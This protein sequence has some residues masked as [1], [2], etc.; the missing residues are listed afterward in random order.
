MGLMSFKE[1]L[2]VDYVPAFGGNRKLKE[3]TVIGIK[4]MNNDGSI[5]FMDTLTD[6][7]ADCK[8]DE[9]RAK[10]SKEVA[11]QTFID[12]V[13]YVK[14]YQV[15]VEKDKVIDIT[16]GEDLYKHGSKGL[17]DEISLAAENSSRLSAGQAKNFEGDSAGS[18]K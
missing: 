9:E 1:G 18:D 17:C 7:L 4:P 5:D 11:K 15:T 14:D 12:H 2:I 6:A 13:G 8:N 3:K 16:N 10:V